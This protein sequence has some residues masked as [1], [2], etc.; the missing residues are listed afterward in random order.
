MSGLKRGVGGAMEVQCGGGAEVSGHVIAPFSS[1]RL[2]P[3]I[4]LKARERPEEEAVASR[5]THGFCAS[6]Q[7]CT[8]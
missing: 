7:Y 5:R 8:A 3:M 1:K 6:E 2:A 4:C